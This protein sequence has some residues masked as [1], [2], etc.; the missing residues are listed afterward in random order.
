MSREKRWN[1]VRM[2]TPTT[3]RSHGGLS[4]D[5][6]R[7]VGV[8]VCVRMRG[9]PEMEKKVNASRRGGLGVS[10]VPHQHRVEVG[11]TPSRQAVERFNAAR[12]AFEAKRCEA[13]EDQRFCECIPVQIW[14][15]SWSVLRLLMLWKSLSCF[16][17]TRPE[18]RSCFSSFL[19]PLNAV[20]SPRFL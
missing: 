14:D 4:K 3:A 10:N 9:R 17:G 18:N 15:P 2:Q 12:E 20:T 1:I 5:G 16:F 11:A 6:V 7:H 8:V 19:E 13:L